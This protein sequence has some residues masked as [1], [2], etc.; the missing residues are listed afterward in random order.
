MI[1]DV[2]INAADCIV[3]ATGFL[4]T[5]VTN[6]CSGAVTRVPHGGFDIFLGAFFTLV[7]LGLI[8]G[9]FGAMWALSR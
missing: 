8:A 7:T 4:A 9:F 6:I 3:K 2:N 5:T 1:N